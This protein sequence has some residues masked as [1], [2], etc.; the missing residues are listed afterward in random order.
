MNFCAACDVPA[1]NETAA[2]AAATT[3]VFSRYTSDSSLET[4]FLVI[5]FQTHYSSFFAERVVLP[6]LPRQKAACAAVRHKGAMPPDITP[7]DFAARGTPKCTHASVK[8]CSTILGASGVDTPHRRLAPLFLLPLRLPVLIRIQ[9]DLI[10]NDSNMKPQRR[11]PTQNSR[12]KSA[13]TSAIR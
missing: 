1:V 9:S 5:R 3:S 8:I 6:T 10:F 12:A 11:N 13:K 7:D 2:M 4:S